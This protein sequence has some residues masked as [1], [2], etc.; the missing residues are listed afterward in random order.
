MKHLLIHQAVRKS[1]LLAAL[2]LTFLCACKEEKSVSLSVSDD[3]GTSIQTE[4]PDI[5]IET[6]DPKPDAPYQQP[7]ISDNKAEAETV[8][9]IVNDTD[10][11]NTPSLDMSIIK[12]IGL[13]GD[14][15]TWGTYSVISNGGEEIESDVNLSWGNILA[16]KYGITPRNYGWGGATIKKWLEVPNLQ[17]KAFDSDDICD[18][19]TIAF[20]INDKNK[21]GVE[22]AKYDRKRLI[23]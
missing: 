8:T 23:T 20:G 7:D 21:T 3:S 2:L 9:G 17:K 16:G 14:S 11:S 10:A 6:T 4:P 12:S 18:V 19:Y 13:I 22:K 15:Y 1:C 5:S